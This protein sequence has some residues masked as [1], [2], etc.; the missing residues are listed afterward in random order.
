MRRLNVWFFAMM[1][2]LG[3]GCSTVNAAN[4]HDTEVLSAQELQARSYRDVGE[5]ES[6]NDI[7]RQMIA[8]NPKS[9]KSVLYQHEIMCNAEKLSNPWILVEEI[10]RTV[11]LFNTACE[12][13]YEGATP[14]AIQRERDALDKYV[15]NN[16]VVFHQVNQK[17]NN[18]V[19]ALFAE[20]LY[21]VYVTNFN[22]SKNICK[23]LYY[24]YIL[25]Y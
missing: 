20:E 9:F 23:V 18:S 5:I 12:A 24:Y 17:T 16:A 2:I 19:Y 7:Y 4:N 1:V 3:T 15:Y 10:K 6:S 22:T 13:H 14:E 25:S 11:Q 21:E 8:A